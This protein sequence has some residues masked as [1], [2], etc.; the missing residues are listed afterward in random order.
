MK[1]S[2]SVVGELSSGYD[3]K[4]VDK[5]QEGL[6]HEQEVAKENNWADDKHTSMGLPI[7]KEVKQSAIAQLNQIIAKISA[8]EEEDEKEMTA[9]LENVILN[10][11]AKEEEKMSNEIKEASK[12]LRQASDLL[13]SYSDKSARHPSEP[14]DESAYER[15]VASPQTGDDEWVDIGPGTFDDLRNEIGKPA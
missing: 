7:P 11:S 12:L 9:S 14:R 15:A 2:Q 3:A 6:A 5:E 1:K 10:I 13:S 4:N 8:L